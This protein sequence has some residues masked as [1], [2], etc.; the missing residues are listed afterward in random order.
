MPPHIQP[1]WPLAAA[2]SGASSPAAGVGHD[3]R[4]FPSV[5]SSRWSISSEAGSWAPPASSDVQGGPNSLAGSEVGTDAEDVQV[6]VA[7]CCGES[8][9]L[10]LCADW[11]PPTHTLGSEAGIQQAWPCTNQL[12][13]SSCLH[14]CHPYNG[15]VLVVRLCIHAPFRQGPDLV[16]GRQ[17]LAWFE[18]RLVTRLGTAAAAPSM[19]PLP[20][21]LPEQ[22]RTT[23]PL[24]AL[25]PLSTTAPAAAAP[26]PRHLPSQW[27]LRPHPGTQQAAAAA[28]SS[29]TAFP[30]AA[31][32]QQF[33]SR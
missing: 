22:P 31:L 14:H 18:D 15:C 3:R 27:R 29:A 5:G 13:S 21:P 4:S 26:A 24:P 7:L 1:Q 19:K 10:A 8:T 32:C 9:Q 25:R 2:L 23:W 17:P 33:S 30:V 6:H 11:M 16:V 20:A 28:V 12:W